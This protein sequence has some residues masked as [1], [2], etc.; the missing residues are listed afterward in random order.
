MKEKSANIWDVT[1]GLEPND[2]LSKAAA[3]CPVDIWNG[4]VPLYFYYDMDT[5]RTYA[6][7]EPFT[8]DMVLDVTAGVYKEE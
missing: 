1:P 6:S 4:V 3:A 2:S 8:D 7:T 5:E